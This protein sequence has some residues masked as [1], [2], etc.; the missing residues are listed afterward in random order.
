M[1]A[2]HAVEITDGQ[3]RT[4]DLGGNLLITVDDAHA[5][6]GNPDALETC[7]GVDGI[8]FSGAIEKTSGAFGRGAPPRH[9]FG[10]QVGRPGISSMASP[11][12]TTLP[13]SVEQVH[14]KRARRLGGNNSTTRTL[15][16]TV[17]PIF[18]GAR[19]FNVCEM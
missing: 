15:A 8:V 5:G 17:W 12:S 10:R 6:R 7:F 13:S 18:T 2:M 3:G 11:S 14:S 4:V 16:V 9:P 1:S 19:K